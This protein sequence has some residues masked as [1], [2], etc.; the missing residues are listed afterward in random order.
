[1]TV[2]RR[3]VNTTTRPVELHLL[4]GVVVVPALGDT[5]CTE[6]DLD[7]GQVK[8]LCDNGVLVVHQNV[9]EESRESKKE[10]QAE[11]TRAPRKGRSPKPRAAK[12]T[13][14]RGAGAV[15]AKSRK[16][17]SDGKETRR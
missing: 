16:R 13:A 9:H 3:L 2:H 15:A 10:P 7:T 4:A 11:S 14:A 17:P 6:E 5:A 8:A 12:S 1:M